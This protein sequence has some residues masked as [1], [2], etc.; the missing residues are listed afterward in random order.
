M[1]ETLESPLP[2]PK[3]HKQGKPPRW[4]VR[5]ALRFR[6]SLLLFAAL[7]SILSLVAALFFSEQ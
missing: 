3:Q 6:L 2:K 4:L 1:Q 5:F 7:S